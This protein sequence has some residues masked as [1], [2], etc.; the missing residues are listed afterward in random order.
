MA[1]G[2]RIPIGGGLGSE[3]LANRLAGTD[4]GNSRCAFL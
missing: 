2:A 1:V 3:R 4:L